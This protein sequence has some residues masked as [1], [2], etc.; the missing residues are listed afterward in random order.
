[1]SDCC[2]SCIAWPGRSVCDYRLRTS[3]TARGAMRREPTP[4]SR[5]R[6][7]GHS[8]YRLYWAHGADAQR[9]F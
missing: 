9:T 6:S 5:R 2:E 1:M 4:R 7:R 3:T 8:N